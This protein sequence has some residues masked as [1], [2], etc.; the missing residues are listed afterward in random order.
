MFGLTPDEKKVIIFFMA[1]LALGNAVLLYK[2][3]HPGAA[4]ELKYGGPD[5]PRAIEQPGSFPAAPEAAAKNRWPVKKLPAG[6][7]DLNRA[8]PRDLE[9]LP[10][11][12]PAMAKRIIDFRKESGD[13]QKIEDLMKVKGIGHKKFNRLREHVFVDH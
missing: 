4:P 10:A 7:I 5:L 3:S 13:F 1:A 8:G 2:K 11:I 6:K 12:G 9:K